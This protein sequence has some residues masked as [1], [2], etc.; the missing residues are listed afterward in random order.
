[1]SSLS[2]TTLSLIEDYEKATGRPRSLVTPQEYLLFR[3]AAMKEAA[4]NSQDSAD[5]SKYHKDEEAGYQL[6]QQRGYRGQPDNDKQKLHY[7]SEPH[8]VKTDKKEVERPDN[9]MITTDSANNDP[10]NQAIPTTA[11]SPLQAENTE[12]DDADMG[13]LAMLK[14]IPG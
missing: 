6:D 3:Q 4:L 9:K 10:D 1:M 11:S 13:L 2:Y 8:V 5:I 7:G 14:A 12:N